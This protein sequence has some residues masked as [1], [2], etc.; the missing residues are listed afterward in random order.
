MATVTSPPSRDTNSPSDA[1]PVPVVALPGPVSLDRP[2][3]PQHESA[4]QPF[5]SSRPLDADPP[6]VPSTFAALDCTGPSLMSMNTDDPGADNQ[7][8][9]WPYWF[10]VPCMLQHPT[11][12]PR[13]ESLGGAVHPPLRP[14]LTNVC[15]CFQA[16]SRYF[17]SASDA[18]SG[19]GLFTTL[20]EAI[21]LAD[22][23]LT[24]RVCFNVHRGEASVSKNIVLLGALMS[25]IAMSYG[26]LTHRLFEETF[27]PNH[28]KATVDILLGQPESPEFSIA[29][30]INAEIYWTLIKN[31]L[32][33]DLARLSDLC[34]AFESRQLKAHDLGHDKCV[35][36]LPCTSRQAGVPSAISN[37]VKTCPRSVDPKKTFSCFRTVYQ[38]SSAIREAQSVINTCK[39][40]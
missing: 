28:D 35:A 38:V 11:L 19:L 17:T 29:M 36:G 13:D 39:T 16:I 10:G 9:D 12:T 14:E 33:E 34:T 26:H 31:A 22:R 5:P 4:N 40:G 15:D 24:C 21:T 27:K 18:S 2:I 8:L 23:V 3:I 30:S 6:P 1:C 37:Y 32:V 7:A 20:R 25:D